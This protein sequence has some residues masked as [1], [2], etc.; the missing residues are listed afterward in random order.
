M[1]LI[2]ENGLVFQV[3]FARLTGDRRSLVG[4]NGEETAFFKI[5]LSGNPRKLNGVREEGRIIK[6]LN[7]AGCVT[8]PTLIGQGTV[9]IQEVLGGLD[10]RSL[11]AEVD[12]D[13]GYFDFVALRHLP[14]DGGFNLA[15]LLLA[16][17]EQRRLGVFHGDIR[18]ENFRIDPATRLLTLIDYD[19][20][21]RLDREQ[22]EMPFADFLRWADAW[23]KRRYAPAKQGG[24]LHFFPDMAFDSHIV[25]LLEGPALKVAT[26]ALL[27]GQMT[28]ANAKTI[29]HSFATDDVV[30]DGERTFDKRLKVL[31]E[32]PFHEGETVL[33]V[34][35]N[36]GLLSRYITGR[37]ARVTGIDLDANVI[38]AARILANISDIDVDFQVVDLD[39]AGLIGRYDTVL[40]FSVLH[41]TQ[42]VPENA[43]KIARACQRIIIE[44][45]SQEGGAKPID[46]Q[47]IS[48]SVWSYPD[49][50]SLSRGL[51]ALFPGF[52][53]ARIKGPVDRDRFIF[54]LR[55]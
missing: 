26:S 43:A 20:A 3:D 39:K 7:A 25:P 47:W 30:V 12:F 50:E 41:H 53:I 10:L 24:L 44:C 38:L 29:Y 8:A 49:V 23:V 13:N 18:P 6:S 34:G 54:E 22:R 36:L 37:G 51:L 46:G 9:P 11:G 4:Y 35:C 27:Q 15:D 5:Q 55:C 19:Q 33:D 42:Y 31:D 2:S 48:T 40:L 32:F 21:I 1:K 17:A 28:T 16:I 52:S 45:R 14:D